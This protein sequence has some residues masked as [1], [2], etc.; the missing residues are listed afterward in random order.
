[1][2]AGPAGRAPE[3]AAPSEGNDGGEADTV[4]TVSGEEEEE[5]ARRPRSLPR[6][7]IQEVIKRRQI[8]LVQVTREERGNKG[9]ALTTYISLAGRYC[10]LMPN[11]TRGGGISRKIQSGE[12]RKRLRA[13]ID[14][15]KLP[16]GMA[17]ILRTA[18]QNRT[19]AEIKRDYDYLLRLWEQIRQS[20]L[21]ATAPAPIH[22]EAN[23]IKRSIRD[24]YNSELSEVLVEGD[25]GYRTAKDF[26]KRLMPSHA[27]RVQPYRDSLPVFTRYRVE[28]Q[29]D[30]MHSPTVQLPSGG[31]IVIS[32]TEALVAI[33]VNSGRAT[34][35]RNIEETATKTNLEAASEIARQLRLRDLAGLVVVDFIDMA[36]RRNARSVE[37]RL[38]E[39][40]QSDRARI[41]MGRISSFGLLEFSR[42]RL[43]PSLQEI[44]SIDCPHC[45]GSGQ[46]R[47]L[48][49]AALHA[50]RSIEEE[51]VRGR[52]NRIR[53]TVP[54][55]VALYLMNRKRTVLG[56][57]EARYGFVVTVETDDSDTPP[58]CRIEVLEGRTPEARA[59]DAVD[60]ATAPDAA[61]NDA[62]AGGGRTGK[63][64]AERRR[65]P[66]RK[67][68]T[69]KRTA[70][71][72]PTRPRT[73][74][75]P[76]RRRRGRRGGRRVARARA[77]EADAVA[78]PSAPSEAEGQDGARG[79]SERCRRRRACGGRGCRR[80]CDG[81]A[82]RRGLDRAPEASAA[83]AQGEDGLR[84]RR[85][86]HGAGGLRG[87]GGSRSRQR[88]GGRSRRDRG[89]AQAPAAAEEERRGRGREDGR[90]RG[91]ERRRRV[92]RRWGE[93]QAAA[94]AE[95]KR[96][97]ADGRRCGG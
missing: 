91:G 89:A 85:G 1:M 2:P 62:A 48:E 7:R 29:L 82:E 87:G 26:M 79:A 42:Q 16:A 3:A 56:E 59:K 10:V 18:G 67:K 51:G 17:V 38:K 69:P 37:R 15:L 6:Y 24:L 77:G 90:R 83:H 52:G 63:T 50:L 11:T 45:A 94:A 86:E 70:R 4:E 60:P 80:R 97:R 53:A 30:S 72:T 81:G 49:S 57:I 40:V 21:A 31:Y 12:A 61:T 65:P 47:S 32:P 88:R 46:I 13:T 58:D 92:R 25:Q 44:S 20:T 9:A 27:K 54:T 33:D 96:R 35:E 22:E 74:I 34:R 95:E 71:A 66:V 76:R 78:A 68:T 41:Q 93:A 75:A 84:T 28:S 8:L 43:R 39:A 73:R 64:G 36:E 5:I 19:K 55:A 23:L 14:A